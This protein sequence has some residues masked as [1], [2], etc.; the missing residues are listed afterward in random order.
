MY[1]SKVRAEVLENEKDV[2]FTIPEEA[3]NEEIYYWRKHHDLHG[4]MEELYFSKGGTNESFNCANLRLREA[5]L[6]R[7]ER[8][9]KDNALPETVGFFFGN[10]PPDKDSNN[11]D[12]AF[13]ARCRTEIEAGYAII[14]SAWY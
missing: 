7:L 2:D 3:E 5:D 8:A 12:L 1:A 6:D 14:Y 13:A 10:N 9:I 4:F 11:A